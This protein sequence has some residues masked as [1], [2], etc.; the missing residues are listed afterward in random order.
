MKKR[1]LLVFL[2]VLIIVFVIILFSGSQKVS[3]SL[4]ETTMVTSKD[5][6]Y[7]YNCLATVKGR[8]HIQYFYGN[9]NTINCQLNDYV[10]KGEMLLTYND[11]YGKKKNLTAQTD[12]YIEEIQ[13]GLIIICDK[14]LYGE[15]YLPLNKYQMVKEND[16]LIIEIGDDY[17]STTIKK[18][19]DYGTDKNGIT[20]YRVE[21]DLQKYQDKLLINQNIS[22]CF[23]LQK[24]YGLVVDNK[25]ILMDEKGYY[26]LDEEYKKKM[27]NKEMYRHDIK[28]L[29][30]SEKETL[31]SGK[32]L[33][34]LMVCIIPEELKELLD[35]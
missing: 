1:C 32:Q 2:L 21:I 26:M 33:E 29:G 9:I 30:R 28:V 13:S 15:V 3:E 8:Q 6:Y 18:K 25:A 17:Y 19:N 22:V 12:G 27:T 10:N 34:G 7:Q 4:I 31:I 5:F 35:D 11:E 24:Q 23:T 16:N 20:C 14:Q